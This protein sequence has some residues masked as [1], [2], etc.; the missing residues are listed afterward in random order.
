MPNIL[1][2]LVITLGLDPSGY[3]KGQKDAIAAVDKT[4][5][6][7]IR[8]AKEMEFRGKQAG[9]FFG[10]IRK[11]I[12]ELFAAFK[13]GEGF[14]N[15]IQDITKSDASLGRLSKTM[16][17]PIEKLAQMGNAA[18]LLGGSQ[19]GMNAT[20]Q[21]LTNSIET[22]RTK[23]PQAAGDFLPILNAMNHVSIMTGHGFKTADQLF[24]DI[25]EHLQGVDPAI[26]TTWLKALGFDQDTIN[27]VLQ[28]AAALKKAMGEVKGEGPTAEQSQIAQQ[29]VSAYNGI[30]IAL[31]DIGRNAWYAT[32]VTPL[33]DFLEK[34]KGITEQIDKWSKAP[35]FSWLGQFSNQF[36]G[37]KQA[38]GDLK[39]SLMDAYETFNKWGHDSG[40]F[41]AIT[42]A[43]KDAGTG[44]IDLEKA[45]FHDILE[46][47]AHNVKALV[48]LLKGN[49]SQAWKDLTAPADKSGVGASGPS[50][51]VPIPPAPGA[52]PAPGGGGIMD[53]IKNWFKSS[54]TGG[55]KLTPEIENYVVKS[56]INAGVD[57]KLALAHIMAESGGDIGAVGDKGSSFG[58]L[59]L[60]YGGIAGGGNAGPGI[61][62]LFTKKTGK[63][64]MDPS[65][66]KDQLDFAMNYVHDHGWNEWHA[67][68]AGNTTND[69]SSR[70]TDTKVTIN[71][72]SNATNSKDLVR[73]MDKHIENSD[74]MQQINFAQN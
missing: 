51:E 42:K 9:E 54:F 20:L 32:L 37:I 33:A 14:K 46:A 24:Q 66:W 57:P 68:I 63:S 59:Q 39:S 29:I 31:T 35:D 40:T 3:I 22:V 36:S 67:P 19:E 1:D 15:F 43:L 44:I 10:Q 34:V 55:G 17:V 65:T 48:E 16:D 47:A 28:G 4:K 2:A 71:V 60:H 6:Q 45:V 64:A 8:A 50:V 13:L 56:A 69:N 70:K 73:D 58:L 27:V 38:A 52:A 11:S 18:K 41:D 74:F 61:G 26:A 5:E 53:S 25:V 21:A 7:S 12:I 72:Y 30:D 49:F 23:G 62:D